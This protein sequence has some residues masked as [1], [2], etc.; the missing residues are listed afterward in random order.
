MLSPCMHLG[1]ES[2]MQMQMQMKCICQGDAN[3]Q[4]TLS[5]FL[6]LCLV[7]EKFL[8]KFKGKK[9]RKRSKIREKMKK[10]KK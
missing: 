1:K 5:Y 3:K 9:M 4:T 6:L 10:I 8:A 2:Q 7:T